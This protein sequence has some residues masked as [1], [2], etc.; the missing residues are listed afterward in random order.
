[1]RNN[2]DTQALLAELYQLKVSLEETIRDFKQA[3]EYGEFL[4]KI[5]ELTPEEQKKCSGILDAIANAV[6]DIREASIG[7]IE[8]EALAELGDFIEKE[9]WKNKVKGSTDCT[10][11]EAIDFTLENYAI[12]WKEDNWEL[13]DTDHGDV[14]EL[15]AQQAAQEQQVH[16]K[17]CSTSKFERLF[18]LIETLST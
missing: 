1:M 11:L 3:Y 5:G 2:A 16:L 9:F 14:L 7:V 8:V 15:K 12:H 10:L 13:D 17:E 18:G 6:E 4:P